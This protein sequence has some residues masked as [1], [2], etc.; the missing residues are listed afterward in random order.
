M[1]TLSDLCSRLLAAQISEMAFLEGR[2]ALACAIGVYERAEIVLSTSSWLRRV[3]PVGA[4]GAAPPSAVEVPY[5]VEMDSGPD[6][7]CWYRRVE[8]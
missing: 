1:D 5:Y 2:M 8:R 4:V 3:F 7:A 6:N